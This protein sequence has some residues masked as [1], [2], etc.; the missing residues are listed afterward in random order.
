MQKKDVYTLPNI[1]N[2][3]SYL[4]GTC[5][6]TSLDIKS[7]YYQIA[8][9]RNNRDK[10]AFITTDGLFKFNAMPFGL[11][12]APSSYLRLMDLKWT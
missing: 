5:F 9:D 6:F 2:I 11:C 8:I 1:D 7:G 4:E 3:L 10:T 12:S